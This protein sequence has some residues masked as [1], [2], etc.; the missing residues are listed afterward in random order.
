MLANWSLGQTKPLG[1]RIFK[2]TIVAVI[3]FKRLAHI[4]DPP[5]EYQFLSL[6]EIA[7]VGQTF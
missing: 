5:G 2:S 7:L 6:T 4:E 1:S 3:S